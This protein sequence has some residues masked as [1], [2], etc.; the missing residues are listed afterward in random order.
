MKKRSTVAAL[1]CAAVLIFTAGILSSAD[2]TVPDKADEFKFTVVS[3]KDKTCK[4]TGG[5]SYHDTYTIP[6]KS[7]EG[8]KVVGIGK[9]AMTYPKFKELIIPDGVEL[10]EEG[11]FYGCHDLRKVQFPKAL[12]T[13][14]KQAFYECYYLEELYF[15]DGLETIGEKTFDYCASLEKITFPGTLKTIGNDNLIYDGHSIDVYYDGTIEDY[16]GLFSRYNYYNFVKVHCTKVSTPTPTPEPTNTPTP[17]PTAT[18]EPTETP[19]PT[20]APVTPTPAPTR[21]VVP[22]PIGISVMMNPDFI[23]SNGNSYKINKNE[24]TLIG[25]TNKGNLVIPDSL[26]TPFNTYKVTGIADSALKGNKTIKSVNIGANVKSIGKDAFNGCKK[27]KKITIR[28]TKLKPKKIGK[29]AFKGIYKKAAFKVPKK[30]KKDYK[31]VIKKM[32]KGA[33]IS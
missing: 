6:A 5:E 27:L 1:I 20:Q 23:T 33:K 32:L 4:L 18:P 19:V 13:I 2:E 25:T 28:S 21:Q 31:K 22:G 24:A 14:E 9:Y 26:T 30:Y 17:K 3:E 8:Y 7:P 11:A 16:Y 12:K 15:Y 10:I 29:N